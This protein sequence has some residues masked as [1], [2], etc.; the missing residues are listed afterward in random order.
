MSSDS[1]APLRFIPSVSAA[2]IEP[3]R[4]NATLPTA[5]EATIPGTAA[6]ETPSD[7]AASG[8]MRAS[9]KPV[10]NQ[11]AKVLANISQVS[12]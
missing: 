7:R 2:P 4:L 3:M 5:T 9:G 12:D 6:S 10:N 11:C 1:N 8:A